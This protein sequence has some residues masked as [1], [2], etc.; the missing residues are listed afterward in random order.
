MA[1]PSHPPPAPRP[2]LLA[3]CDEILEVQRERAVAYTAFHAGFKTYLE[4]G[5]E[6]PYRFLMAQLTA[7]FQALSGRAVAVE[8]GFRDGLGL[9]AAAD[10]VRAL[11]GAEKRKL[12]ATL[13]LQAVR[14]AVEQRRFSWQHGEG[15]VGGEPQCGHD[16]GHGH[17]CGAGKAGAPPPPPEPTEADVKGATRESYRE[18]EACVAAINDAIAELQELRAE[19]LEAAA[20]NGG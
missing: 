17:S 3:L 1:P 8:A 6:G 4:T 16:H 7:Q 20:G 19:A 18:M 12:E 10:T 9:A 11:Q 15:G 13:A 2:T 5:V 14:A